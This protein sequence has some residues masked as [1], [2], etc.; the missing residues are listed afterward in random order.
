MTTSRIGMRKSDPAHRASA[1]TLV[2]LILVMA[3]L[4]TIMALAAPSLSRSMHSRNLAHEATRFLAL[5]EYG[6]NEA[7]SQGVPMLIW[8]DAHQARYGLQAKTGYADATRH[9]REYS[10]N[11]DV[12]FDGVTGEKSGDVIH[13]I[14]FAPDGTLDPASTGAVRLVDRFDST[15]LINRTADGWGYEI[16][17]EKE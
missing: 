13:A 12:Q 1:F 3:L 6:R 7:I 5:T 14:E 10:L 8:V 11:A 4:A 16:V 15:M 17:K 2:E 9:E